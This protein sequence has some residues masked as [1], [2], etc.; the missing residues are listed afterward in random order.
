MQ[1]RISKWGNSLAVR[2]PKQLADQLCLAEGQSVDLAVVDNTIK[3]EPQPSA[4]IPR[5]K[6][7]DLLAQCDPSDQPEAIDWGP[8]V[9]A[10]I[11]DDDYSRGLIR[12]NS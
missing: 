8:D 12:E 9:G 4:R 3:I 7:A 1:V 10:E 2:L 6:L 11:I 5:Y